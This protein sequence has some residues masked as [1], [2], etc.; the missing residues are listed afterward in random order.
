MTRQSR[1]RP[2]LRQHGDS[3]VPLDIVAA[4]HAPGVKQLVGEGQ[5]DTK[6]E[7][8]DEYHKQ[9]LHLVRLAGPER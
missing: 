9:H 5:A 6:A 8:H 3:K 7:P 1:Y 4:P 2:E